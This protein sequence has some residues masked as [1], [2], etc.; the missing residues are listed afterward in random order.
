MNTTEI[1]SILFSVIDQKYETH[2]LACNQLHYIK[3]EQ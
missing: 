1:L 3:S 2:V